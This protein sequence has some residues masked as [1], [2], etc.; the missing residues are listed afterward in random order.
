MTSEIPYSTEDLLRLKQK[1]FTIFAALR[2][3]LDEGY[4]E[5]NQMIDEYLFDDFVNNQTIRTLTSNQM[6]SIRYNWAA[7]ILALI[8]INAYK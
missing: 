6:L 8:N 1:I 2:N 7:S 3:Q 4:D 5:L